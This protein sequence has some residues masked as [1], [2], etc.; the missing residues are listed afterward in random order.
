MLELIS[1]SPIGFKLETHDKSDYYAIREH[2]F[3]GGLGSV[4]L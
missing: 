3:N 1:L 4:H 2:N